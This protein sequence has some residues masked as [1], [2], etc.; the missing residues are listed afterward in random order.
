NVA[1]EGIKRTG[2][3]ASDIGER[4]KLAGRQACNLAKPRIYKL[5]MTQQ[6]QQDYYTT[7]EEGATAEFRDRG[8]QFIGITLPVSS[9]EDFKEKLAA[10]KKQHPKAAHHCF[11]YRIGLDGNL[12]RA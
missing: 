9:V 3:V 2:I 12:F 10:I 4:G 5:L 11:A 1:G 7:I 8:S 6:L